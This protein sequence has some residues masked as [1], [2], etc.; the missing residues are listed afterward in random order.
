MVIV[1]RSVKC[2]CGS[3]AYYPIT[4]KDDNTLWKCAKCKKETHRQIR[5]RKGKKEPEEKATTNSA[6][7]SEHVTRKK[8]LTDEEKRIE[9]KKKL[10]GIIDKAEAIYV[11]VAGQ[12]M[13]Y[14]IEISAINA[15]S[16]LDRSETDEFEID[17]YNE[18][19]TYIMEVACPVITK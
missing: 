3:V 10:F 16:I 14:P 19:G 9:Y 7:D 8:V 5:K 1:E 12:S 4:D 13:D 6:L 15:K 17:S 18:H 11:Y 2:K